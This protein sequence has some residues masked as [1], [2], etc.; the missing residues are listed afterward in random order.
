MA[1]VKKAWDGGY[2][3]QEKFWEALFFA[4]VGGMLVGRSFHRCFTPFCKDESHS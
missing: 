2:L 1:A 4:A 3:K